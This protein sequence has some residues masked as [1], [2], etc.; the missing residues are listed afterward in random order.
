MSALGG[1]ATELMILAAG[2]SLYNCDSMTIR[3]PAYRRF[4]T[5]N[6]LGQL[7]SCEGWLGQDFTF[8]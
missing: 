6:W 1:S 4:H 7:A 2:L 5:E 3:F 8:V